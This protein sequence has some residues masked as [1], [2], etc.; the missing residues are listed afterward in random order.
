VAVASAAHMQI[1]ISAQTD[2]HTSI[3][4]LIT[5]N[6]KPKQSYRHVYPRQQHSSEPCDLDLLT[7]G[8]T[9]ADVLPFLLE[10]RNTRTVTQ[11][12]RCHY[13]PTHKLAT[14][15]GG[16]LNYKKCSEQWHMSA[17]QPHIHIRCLTLQSTHNA[18]RQTE[19]A[20]RYLFSMGTRTLCKCYSP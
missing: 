1:C 11:S 7:L 17:F 8:S 2:N 14:E 6:Q 10:Y 5:C 20:F 16:R 3:P 4:P 15:S 19:N 13:H 18:L 9:H 12:H